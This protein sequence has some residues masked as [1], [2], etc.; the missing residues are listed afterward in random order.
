MS[1]YYAN[2]FASVLKTAG[3]WDV[4]KVV[5]RGTRDSADLANQAR[6]FTIRANAEAEHMRRRNNAKKENER[7]GSNA[8]NLSFS[9]KVAGDKNRASNGDSLQKMYPAQV[10]PFMSSSISEQSNPYVRS[11]LPFFS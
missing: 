8:Q 4:T 2:G 10:N 3:L 7:E 6:D 9:G 1:N 11:L 5:G